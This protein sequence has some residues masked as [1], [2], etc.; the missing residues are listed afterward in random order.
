[1][2]DAEEIVTIM[3]NGELLKTLERTG[4]NLA[5]ISTSRKES[6]AEHSY[7]VV[8]TA[9]LLS[10]HLQY[11]RINIDIE[12]ILIMAIL[13]DI[14]E[15]ITGDI[16][17]TIENEQ[18]CE[19]MQRKRQLEKEAIHR[20]LDVANGLYSR[21][22]DLWE[23]YSEGKS[24]ESRIVRGAD[25]LDMIL[26]ARKLESSTYEH[27]KLDQFYQSSQNLVQSLDLSIVSDIFEQLLR[28]HRNDA[29]TF[30]NED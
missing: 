10:Q 11:T 12:K 6:V 30:A 4:W 21:F 14:Q 9:L 13:H 29:R 18:N 17:R 23:E 15:S 25:I 2:K 24:L 1:M 7:G 26:H 19:F 20:I 28:E 27:Q 5:G 8:L 22:I 3:T 16:P